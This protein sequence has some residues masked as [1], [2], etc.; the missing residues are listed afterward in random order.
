VVYVTVVG[1]G[2]EPDRDWRVELAGD[3]YT[4]TDVESGKSTTHR[5]NSYEFEHNSLIKLNIENRGSETF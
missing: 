5:V 2:E 4:V 3:S 1:Q